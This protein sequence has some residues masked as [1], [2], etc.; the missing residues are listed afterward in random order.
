M[1]GLFWAVGIM[2]VIALAGGVLDLLAW[3][4]ELFDQ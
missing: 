1:S 2:V 3:M 4:M